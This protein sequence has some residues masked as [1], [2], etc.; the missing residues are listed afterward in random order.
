MY[1]SLPL[2]PLNTNPGAMFARAVL[3]SEQD[4]ERGCSRVGRLRSDGPLILRNSNPKGPEPLAHR[5]TKVARVALASGTA[6]PLGGDEYGLEVRVGAGSTLVL[7][8]A[9]AMLVLPGLGG[10]QSTMTVKVTV[11]HGATFVWW[12]EPIIAAS[13]CN[14]R[15]KVEIELAGTARLVMREE[16]L[17]GRHGEDP[18]D[19]SSRL[20][21]TRDTRP[22]YDQQVEFGPSYD[23]WRGAAVLG[24]NSAV[25]SVIAVDPDWETTPPECD[26]FDRNAALTPLAGPGVCISAV[27]PDSLALRG[28][29]HTGLDKLGAPYALNK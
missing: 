15:H 12:A 17:L 10:G 14:H 19:L 6:G 28:L 27:A 1:D 23:G 24:G 11:E 9:S 3:S 26:P 7:T 8:E 20:R 16:I 25:G 4:F 5:S 21:I 22:L 2:K 29:L 13:R 18:G